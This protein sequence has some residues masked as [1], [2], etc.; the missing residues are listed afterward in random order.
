M[1]VMTMKEIW[2]KPSCAATGAP[3]FRMRFMTLRWGRRSSRPPRMLR[4]FTITASDTA[5]L[6]A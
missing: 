4:R 1:T 6:T 2:M 3:T 5:T